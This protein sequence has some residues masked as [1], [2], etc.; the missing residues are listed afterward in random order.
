MKFCTQCQQG[1]PEEAI[2]CHQCGSRFGDE[3]EAAPSPVVQ[4]E[5][6]WRGFIGPSKS[7]IFNFK[8]LVSFQNVFSWESAD[9]YYM[10]Q[11]R[12][13]GERANPRFAL[14][15]HWPAFLLDPFFWFLY[16]KMYLYAAVYLVGPAISVYLTGDIMVGFVWRIVAGASANYLYFWHVKDHLKRIRERAGLHRPIPE[17]VIRDTGGVQPYVFALAIL[18]HLFVLFAIL[19]GPP[20]QGAFQ[21]EAEQPAGDTRFY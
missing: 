5:E 4:E 11:F 18:L 1:N 17:A 15:W 8:N 3:P 12:N 10:E 19:K 21:G 7:I 14:T 16:R 2:F 13:F 20:E 9:R 6:L